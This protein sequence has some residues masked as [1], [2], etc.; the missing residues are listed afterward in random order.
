[1]GIPICTHPINLHKCIKT[2]KKRR[3]ERFYGYSCGAS[4]YT[5]SFILRYFQPHAYKP[6]NNALQVSALS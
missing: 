4:G 5:L 2:A 1:M 3:F 6:G